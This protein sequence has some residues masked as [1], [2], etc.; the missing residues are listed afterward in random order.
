MLEMKNRAIGPKLFR[1]RRENVNQEQDAR[2]RVSA[3]RRR[4][5][6]QPEDA[7][8]VVDERRAA[9]RGELV[10][11]AKLGLGPED[12]D[13][14]HRYPGAADGL[15]MAIRVGQ[16]HVS[17][18]DKFRPDGVRVPGAG[19]PDEHAQGLEVER[20]VGVVEPDGVAPESLQ[21]R[22]Q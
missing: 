12:L 20:E 17:N 10:E 2:D 14:L 16:V 19:R 18:S 15:R 11:P 7:S 21:R 13:Q 9:P 6:L 22:E 3:D 1:S 5:Q 8:V 4:R